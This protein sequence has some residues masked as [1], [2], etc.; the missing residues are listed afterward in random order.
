[1]ST[2]PRLH[3]ERKEEHKYEIHA[4]LYSEDCMVE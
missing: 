4:L 2:L 3:S 1:M